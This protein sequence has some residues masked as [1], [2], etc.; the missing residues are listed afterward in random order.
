MATVPI[1]HKLVGVRDPQDNW[2]GHR[3]RSDL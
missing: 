2:L 1:G 3:R